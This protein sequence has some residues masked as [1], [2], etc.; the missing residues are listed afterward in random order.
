[1]ARC[2]ICD[3]KVEPRSVNA[4]FPFCTARCKTID[5]GKWMNEEYRIP[6]PDAELDDDEVDGLSD[7]DAKAG[8]DVRH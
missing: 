2:P 4:S 7:A 1:M 8:G 6:V 5:L 3:K